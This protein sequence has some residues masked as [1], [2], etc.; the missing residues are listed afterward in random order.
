MSGYQSEAAPVDGWSN[1][2]SVVN[3]DVNTNTLTGFDQNDFRWTNNVRPLDILFIET[4][5]DQLV[6]VNGLQAIDLYPMLK[7][8]NGNAP[9]IIHSCGYGNTGSTQV[10]V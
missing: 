9:T 8:P 4:P 7:A 6:S 2:T 5:I 3:L 1:L 10:G